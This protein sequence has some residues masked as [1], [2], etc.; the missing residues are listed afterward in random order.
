MVRCR[1]KE[2][3][4]TVRIATVEFIHYMTNPKDYIL[5]V[6]NLKTS[7]RTPSGK[8][9]AV[10]RISFDVKKGKT[11]CI[12]G[13]SGC[14][15]SVTSLSILRLLPKDVASIEEGQILFNG[16]DLLKFSEEEIRK[17]RGNKI[18]MIFQEPMSSLNPVY[19]IGNQIIEAL[20][21]HRNMSANAA[22]D[23]SIQLLRQ[24]GIP[25]PESRV[26]DYPHQ[27]S[28]GM[29]QRAMIA[30]A[31]ACKPDL[32][33]ADE[34]TTALDVTIQAQILELLAELQKNLGMTLILIT[35]DL[36][37]VSDIG[38]DVA[39]MYAGTIVEYGSKKQIFSNPQHPY[40]QGLL[41]SIPKLNGATKEVPLETIGGSVPNL[42]HLPTGCRFQERCKFV[43]DDCKKSEP[44]LR[45]TKIEESNG[46]ES[47]DILSIG[48]HHLARCIMTF[49]AGSPPIQVV[50]K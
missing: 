14:G 30:M 18:A 34:P 50:S 26:D 4:F 24:V 5:S 40:T 44:E 16:Q 47:S 11:F 19:S 31:L 32:L 20:R 37:V 38:D 28:G 23:E 35:H 2:N 17:I 3:R 21:M 13:E 36:G 7:F 29:R 6:R 12:V 1:N 33:I 10:D 22:R 45:K 9:T 8:L 15:K 25:A 27:L 39:V 41:K 49:N 42:L 43:V 46:K 48:D